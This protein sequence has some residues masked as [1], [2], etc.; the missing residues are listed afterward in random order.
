LPPLTKWRVAAVHTETG[1][2]LSVS[3]SG[4]DCAAGATPAPE[5]N[6]RRCFPQTWTPP[7]AAEPV[8]DWFHKYVVTQVVAVDNT[9]GAPFDTTSYEYVGP[10]AW[11]H[12][13][14][15]LVP[16]K[17]RTWSQWRGYGTVRVVHGEP[18]GPRSLVQHLYFRGM[19]GDV[20]PGGRFRS[21]KVTDSQGTSITDSPRLRGYERESIVY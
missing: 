14:N 9:G 18:T 4:T 15:E 7:D 8:P 12:D 2:T 11:A 16:A 6:G 19:D 13:D 3:Y 10:G 1:G 5:D 21:V 20:L 17:R